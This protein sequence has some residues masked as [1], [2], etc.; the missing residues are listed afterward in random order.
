[1][2]FRGEKYSFL[3]DLVWNILSFSRTF[4]NKK[5]DNATAW[6]QW[7]PIGQAIPVYTQ[8]NITKLLRTRVIA[9]EYYLMEYFEGNTQK[10]QGN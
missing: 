6:S 5:N 2:T 1:M 4:C 8:L 3:Q 9:L 7:I 10:Q